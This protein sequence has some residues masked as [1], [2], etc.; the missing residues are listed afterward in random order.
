MVNHYQKFY[1]LIFDMKV[2]DGYSSAHSLV[3]HCVPG[4]AATLGDAIMNTKQ[5]SV[6][7]LV[8]VLREAQVQNAVEAQKRCKSEGT[9][10]KSWHL[11]GFSR[12]RVTKGILS[13]GEEDV[14]QPSVFYLGTGKVSDQLQWGLV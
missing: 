6:I 4:C 14:A 7:S 5:S 8:C 11:T 12:K 3:I 9:S 13:R 1:S 2:E 10:K